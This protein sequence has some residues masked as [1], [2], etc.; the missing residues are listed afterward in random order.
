MT[1]KLGFT[2][3]MLDTMTL[4]Q[5]ASLVRIATSKVGSISFRIAKIVLLILQIIGVKMLFY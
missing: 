4:K 1:A 3:S 5:V 2:I